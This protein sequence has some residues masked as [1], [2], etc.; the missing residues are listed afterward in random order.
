MSVTIMQSIATMLMLGTCLAATSDNEHCPSERFDPTGLNQPLSVAG[1]AKAPIVVVGVVTGVREIGPPQD[2]PALPE[3]MTQCVKISVRLENV[4]KGPQ[5]LGLDLSFYYYR[6]SEYSSRDLGCLRYI[7]VPGT[8]RM[9]FLTYDQ[10]VLRSIGDVRDYTLRV[11]GG[12]HDAATLK[13]LPFAQK[14]ANVLLTQGSDGSSRDF[15]LALS[16]GAFVSDTLVSTE[17]TDSLLVR[18]LSQKDATLRDAA[19]DLLEARHTP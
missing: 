3:T 10:N 14:V 11:L 6:F 18:L 12:F 13:D 7:P 17:Y 5:N 1:F 16:D 19:R 4:L 8:R 2:S 9:F 15:V